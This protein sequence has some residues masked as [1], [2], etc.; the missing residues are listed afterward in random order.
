MPRTIIVVSILFLVPLIALAQTADPGRSWQ[1][2]QLTT[3][4]GWVYEGVQVT[5]DPADP[6]IVVITKSDGATRRMPLTD[7][8]MIRDAD[9]RDI[10]NEIIP[11][12]VMV[13][14]PGYSEIGVAAPAAA[15]DSRP[16]GPRPFSA[17][18]GAAIRGGAA[19]CLAASRLARS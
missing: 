8:R 17:M 5:T 1:D 10:T 18:L 9:G 6:T 15:A 13:V 12:P 14:P 3:H 7:I 4:D 2:V 16:R 19:D 11:A